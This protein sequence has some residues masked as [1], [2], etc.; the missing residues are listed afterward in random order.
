MFEPPCSSLALSLSEASISLIQSNT[1]VYSLSYKNN[2]K[3]TDWQVILA[4][5]PTFHLVAKKLR[6]WAD[7]R[8]T[9]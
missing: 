2:R 8:P 6:A 1:S 5:A 7:T 4:F 9:V 3:L